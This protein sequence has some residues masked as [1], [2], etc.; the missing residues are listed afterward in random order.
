MMKED[1]YSKFNH[2]RPNLLA[3]FCCMGDAVV[4]KDVSEN[5]C[6]QQLTGVGRP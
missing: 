4:N 1:R 5:L 2:E 6:D 3:H